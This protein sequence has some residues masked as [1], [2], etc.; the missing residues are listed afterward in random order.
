MTRRATLGIWSLAIAA[1]VAPAFAYRWTANPDAVSYID[2]AREWM[3]RPSLHAVSTYWSPLFSWMLA[4]A[5]TVTHATPL[6]W[7][8]IGHGVSAICFVGTLCSAAALLRRVSGGRSGDT[9][10][11]AAAL[12]AVALAGTVSINPELITPDILLCWMTVLASCFAID[13]IT[14]PE[15]AMP[16]AKLGLVLGIAYLAKAIALYIAGAT[17]AALVVAGLFERRR[18]ARPMLI[19]LAGFVVV[20]SPWVAMQSRAIGALTTGSAG[21]VVYA[22]EVLGVPRL[23]SLMPREGV[24]AGATLARGATLVGATPWL[25]RA[26]STVP[27]ASPFQ[28][29]ISRWHEFDARPRIDV[30]AIWQKFLEQLLG[31]WPP[32]ALALVVF[33]VLLARGRGAVPPRTWSV[34]IVLGAPLFVVG[35]MYLL[36]LSEPRYLAPLWLPLAIV[37][38]SLLAGSR[39]EHGD[40][41]VSRT[42][43]L[44]PLIFFAVGVSPALLRNVTYAIAAVRGVDLVP[45]SVQPQLAFLRRSGLVSGE[46]VALIGDPYEVAWAVPLDVRV[47]LITPGLERGELFVAMSDGERAALFRALHAQGIRHLIIR[48]PVT[49]D[50]AGMLTDEL[51]ELGV[52]AVP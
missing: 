2:S 8:A 23:G 39:R 44:A 17:F 50:V 38:P 32:F 15:R 43:I 31:S 30:A 29:D 21:G 12:A 35:G 25:V 46:Q 42:W 34:L 41:R 49:R 20:V 27:G 40:A 1:G 52:V 13:M 26:D 22:Q 3:M 28:Y 14:A 24:S 10:V 33:G 11:L 16:A 37:A 47:S 5:A 9:L 19:A 7:L 36:I 51:A 4:L 18:V 6:Y 48:L 45:E